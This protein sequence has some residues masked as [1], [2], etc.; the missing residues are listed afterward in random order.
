VNSCSPGKIGWVPKGMNKTKIVKE[1]KKKGK[2]SVCL[3]QGDQY[4]H[5]RNLLYQRQA[6]RKAIIAVGFQFY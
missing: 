1:K 5:N 4:K 6:Y 2:R 3:Q